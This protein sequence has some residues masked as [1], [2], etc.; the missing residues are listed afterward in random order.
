MTFLHDSHADGSPPGTPG[1]IMARVDERGSVTPDRDEH[2]HRS[3]PRGRAWARE[4]PRTRP[5]ETSGPR[6]YSVALITVV[7]ALG[8]A[9]LLRPLAGIENVDLVFLTAVVGVAVSCASVVAPGWALVGLAVVPPVAVC[10]PATPVTPTLTASAHTD[11]ERASAPPRLRPGLLLELPDVPGELVAD[12]I[13]R[14]LQELLLRLVHGQS[15]HPLER[16]ESLVLGLLEL[17]LERLDVHLAVTEPLLAPL[18]LQQLRIRLGLLLEDALL[19]LHDLQAPALHLGFDL[20]P[21]LD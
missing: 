3:R 21:K 13:L 17:L 7:A 14:P 4:V 1:H 11:D 8:L 5:G 6:A 2:G 10:A 20:A 18:E 12:E 9:L 15:R 19:D 16:P